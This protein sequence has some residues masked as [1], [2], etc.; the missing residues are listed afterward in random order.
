MDISS[1]GFQGAYYKGYV[2]LA[3]KYF[4]CSINWIL[5]CQISIV[6]N[7]DLWKAWPQSGLIT[8]NLGKPPLCIL[9]VFKI[10]SLHCYQRAYYCK[11]ISHWVSSVSQSCP[12]LCDPIDCSTPEFPVHQQLPELAQTH[13][14]WV[15]DAIQPS[16]SLSMK[17]NCLA[18]RNSVFYESSHLKCMGQAHFGEIVPSVPITVFIPTVLLMLKCYHLTSHFPESYHPCCY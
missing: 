17:E 9:F 10:L 6:V 5:T 8:G 12:T 11:N 14:H 15:G 16:H 2:Q 13:V 1:W 7:T 18:P 3:Q 4:N